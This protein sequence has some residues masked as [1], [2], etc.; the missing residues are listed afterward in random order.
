M[1]LTRLRDRVLPA[2]LAPAA[3]PATPPAR[4]RRAALAHQAAIDNILND[5]GLAA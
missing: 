1:I 2:T 5:A 3:I 4:L